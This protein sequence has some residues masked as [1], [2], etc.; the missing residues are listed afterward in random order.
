MRRL[1]EHV[2]ALILLGAVV[3]A[4]GALGIAA[5]VP[6]V[7]TD[8]PTRA[9]PVTERTG[10]SPPGEE[11]GTPA[12]VRSPEPSRSQ[13]PSRPPEPGPTRREPPVRPIPVVDAQPYDPLGDGH[14]HDAEIARTVDGRA[15]TVWV[16]EHY[17][18]PRFGG[19]KPGV[20]VLVDLGRPRSVEAVTLRLLRGGG[21]TVQLR[22][23]NQ[24]GSLGGLPVVETL[25]GP[26]PTPTIR[27]PESTKARYWLVWFTRVPA[28]GGHYRG[29]V[30]E[31]RFS[32]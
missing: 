25:A 15:R 29:G 8:S 20:G 9:A 11:S 30:A 24:P 22:A 19:L 23:G 32:G 12:A 26:G 7:D 2:A 5:V 17:S 10:I 1:V 27:P 6:D 3:G 21:S 13:E 4:V 14:E 28:E 18:T 31:I 16:T